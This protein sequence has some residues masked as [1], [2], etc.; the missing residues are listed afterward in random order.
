VQSDQTV[1]VDQL[2]G[3]AILVWDVQDVVPTERLA[4]FLDILEKHVDDVLA[5]VPSNLVV[6]GMMAAL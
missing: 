1:L 5:A 4:V 6:S 3:P 2:A